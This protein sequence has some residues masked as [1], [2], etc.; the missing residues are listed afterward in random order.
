MI[1]FIFIQVF[2][3]NGSASEKYVIAELPSSKQLLNLGSDAVMG[4]NNGKHGHG[5]DF[6]GGRRYGSKSKNVN[7]IKIG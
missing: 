1:F 4:G 7:N 2:L 5:E 3:F 6:W